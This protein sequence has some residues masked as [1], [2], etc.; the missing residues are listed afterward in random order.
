MGPLRS[1]QRGLCLEQSAQPTTAFLR[2]RVSFSRPK[3][4]HVGNAVEITF[5][6]LCDGEDYRACEALQRATWGSDFQEVVP[7]AVLKIVQKVG[8]VATGAFTADAVMAGFVFGITGWKE[9]KPCHWSHMLAVDS[10]FRDQGIGQRLKQHQRDDLRRRGVDVMFWTYDPLVARNAHMNLCRLG[11]TVSE[12]VPDMY[13]VDDDN[14]LDSVLGTDRFIVEWDLTAQPVRPDQPVT[15]ARLAN[16]TVNPTGGLLPS[17]VDL[18]SW[19]RV[20]IGIPGDIHTLKATAPDLAAAWRA[21]TRKA[22]LHYLATGYE[23][24]GFLTDDVNQ[25]GFYQLRQV[26]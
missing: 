7:G 17:N 22:F 10:Q 9:G 13:G 2:L 21:N 23:V 11:V 24:T 3:Q 4:C 1:L 18:P 12:Y 19:P 16:A 25:A 20:S 26:D 6:A 8:G 15:E 14:S 5:R